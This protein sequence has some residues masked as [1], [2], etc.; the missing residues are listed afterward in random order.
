M[1]AA[2][3]F[4]PNTRS[5]TRTYFLSLPSHLVVSNVAAKACKCSPVPL[6][7]S[8]TNELGPEFPVTTDSPLASPEV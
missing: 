2:L 7:S 5:P 8:S 3:S 4:V 6:A 1:S